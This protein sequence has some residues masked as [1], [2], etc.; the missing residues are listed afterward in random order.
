M[1]FPPLDFSKV[2]TFPV[3]DRSNKV[4][5]EGFGRPHVAGS[6]LDAF[7]KSLPR[8]RQPTAA[9]ID[10]AMAGNLCRCGTYAR[11]RAAVADAAKALA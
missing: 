5:V 1:R 9:Q 10:A 7:L 2:R 6:G 4:A 11:I 8:G 3:A